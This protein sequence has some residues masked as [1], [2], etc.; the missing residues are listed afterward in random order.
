MHALT[1][2]HAVA[3]CA[4]LAAAGALVAFAGPLDPPDGP[5]APT[6]KTLSEVEPRT[7]IQSLVG[8][9]S[10]VA[11][12]SKSGSYYLAGDLVVPNG[13]CGIRIVA[14]VTHV[15]IDLGG[16]TIR[17]QQQAALEGIKTEASTA[18]ITVR[19]GRIRGFSTGLDAA[20]T[21]ACTV[22]RLT[23]DSCDGEGILTGFVSSLTDCLV[24]ECGNNGINAASQAMVTRCISQGNAGGGIDVDADSMVRDCIATGNALGISTNHGCTVAGCNAAG[25]T[26]A[27]IFTTN[28]CVVS[29]SVGRAN[30]GAGIDAAGE[31][32]VVR[33][34]AARLNTG[35]GIAAGYGGV[36]S[37]CAASANQDGI[38]AGDGCTVSACAASANQNGVS[39]GGWGSVYGCSAFENRFSGVAFGSFSYIHTNNASRNVLDDPQHGAFFTAG[40]FSRIDENMTHNNTGNGLRTDGQSN[41]IMRNVINNFANQ[42]NDHWLADWLDV[43]AWLNPSP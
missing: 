40:N 32:V 25:N 22:E 34:C 15:T 7:P 43:D 5:I 37:G 3:C 30:G 19:N 42:E 13:K 24:Q 35:D 16:F 8:N 18:L 27:G 12:I 28:T 17:E 2:R 29:D 41:Y 10:S 1:P 39:T 38:S 4:L 14:G 31:A 33:D 9:G 26:G 20:N 23:V 6:Y 11:I 36:V 21:Q